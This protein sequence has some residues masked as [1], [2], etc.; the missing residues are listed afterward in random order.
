MNHKEKIGIPIF[1]N[2]GDGIEHVKLESAEHPIC[3]I[4][5]KRSGKKKAKASKHS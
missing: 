5:L 3:K 4:E 2:V 1:V